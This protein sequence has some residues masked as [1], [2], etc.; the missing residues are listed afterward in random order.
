MMQYPIFFAAAQKWVD[1]PRKYEV[2]RDIGERLSASEYDDDLNLNESDD[3]ETAYDR[4]FIVPDS[5]DEGYDGDGDGDEYKS[6]SGEQSQADTSSDGEQS[7]DALS[8]VSPFF[9]P[10]RA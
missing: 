6:E 5:E 3:E 2:T 8:D 10:K 9:H 7:Q 4:Q 1:N